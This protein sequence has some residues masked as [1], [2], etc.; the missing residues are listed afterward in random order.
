MRVKRCPDHTSCRLQHLIHPRILIGIIK[1]LSILFLIVFF[2]N[3]A[4][5]TD[6]WQVPFRQSEHRSE[7][8][9]SDR[10]PHEK[11]PPSTQNAA[12]DFP[13]W[14]GKLLYEFFPVCLI[15]IS[16]LH[17]TVC[18]LLIDRQKLFI[19]ILHKTIRWEKISDSFPF[20]PAT[21]VGYTKQC[22]ET[23]QGSVRVYKLLTSPAD[24]QQTLLLAKRLSP[25]IPHSYLFFVDLT[26]F[27]NSS[28]GKQC[29]REK[30]R[31]ELPPLDDTP[32]GSADGFNTIQA[33]D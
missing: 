1:S 6:L 33:A 25:R 22:D 23:L 11:I 20:L 5:V 31:A 7:D 4:L 24:K 8:L 9:P 16:A 3:F 14:I 28:S 32:A 18:F 19:H 2:Q 27:Y 10:S 29:R 21:P 17:H 12:R 30:D 26:D 15:H 13:S